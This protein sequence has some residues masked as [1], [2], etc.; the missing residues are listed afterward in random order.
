METHAQ[1]DDSISTRSV[2]EDQLRECFG[3]VAYAHKTH[4]K[5]ADIY[6][7][8]QNLL[9]NGQIVLSSFTT[10]GFVGTFFDP[11]KLATYVGAF[12]SI[13]LLVLNAYAKQTNLGEL[14]QKHRQ[15][16]VDL[17]NIRESYV[18]LIADVVMGEKPIESLQASRDELQQSLYEIYKAA[19]S[20]LDA[21]YSRA[22]RALQEKGDLTFTETE[23][24]HF[25]PECLKKFNRRVEGIRP[26]DKTLTR[27]DRT[28]LR[29]S[30]RKAKNS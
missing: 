7:A 25:L 21:G 5:T 10:A 20:T 22:Q 17:W 11:G 14:I 12:F 28:I 4:E 23:I 2:L 1:T 26:E 29:R 27:V 8:R 3:R 15:T 6:F 9:R 24:D 13:A 16:A 18:S 19:P 30:R